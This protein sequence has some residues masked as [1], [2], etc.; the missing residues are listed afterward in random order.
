M[1][2]MASI[3]YEPAD[4]GTTPRQRLSPTKRLKIFELRK[5]ICC[6]CKLAIVGKKWIDEHGRAL[7]LGGSNDDGNRYVAHVTC[8]AIKTREEDMPRIVK[9]KAQKIAHIGAKPAPP[10]PI[11]SAPF[12]PSQRTQERK[13]SGKLGLPNRTKDIFGRPL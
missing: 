4:V 2:R 10:R 5:G 1:I 13:A 7:G 3:A 6:I 8:A 11:R 12:R 9:A